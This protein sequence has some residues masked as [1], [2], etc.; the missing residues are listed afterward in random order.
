MAKLNDKK[1]NEILGE[2]SG[3]GPAPWGQLRD[4]YT[5]KMGKRSERFTRTMMDYAERWPKRIIIS[6][7]YNV[8]ESPM[9]EVLADE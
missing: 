9:V 4:L 6:R 2:M 1:L 7:P 5:G 3:H 8:S